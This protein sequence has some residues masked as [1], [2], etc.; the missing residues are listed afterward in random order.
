MPA[1]GFK[2]HQDPRVAVAELATRLESIDRDYGEIRSMV[3]ALGLRIDEIATSIN[4]K[5][6]ARSAPQYMTMIAAATM[7]G[8]VFFAFIAPI[9]RTQEERGLEIRRLDSEQRAFVKDMSDTLQRRSELFLTNREHA[10]SQRRIDQQLEW[11]KADI[12]RI[13]AR[14]K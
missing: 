8:G 2:P 7:V 6:D 14:I 3:S 4:T 5:L 12:A 11:F 10:E 13:D 1:R 9:Q